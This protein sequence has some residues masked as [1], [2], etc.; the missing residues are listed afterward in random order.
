MKGK[1]T[2]RYWVGL[3]YFLCLAALI[4][5]T[6]RTRAQEIL[7]IK[8]IQVDIWPEYDRPEV[9]VIYRI[10]LAE[11]TVLPAGMSLRIP[12]QAAKPYNLAMRDMGGMLYNLDYTLRLEG[13]WIWVDFETPSTEIQLEYYDPRIRKDKLQRNFDFTWQESYY[14]TAMTVKVQQP[15]HS[16]TMKITPDM[17]SGNLGQDGLTYFTSMFNEVES[18]Q[19]VEVEISYEKSEDTLSTQLIPVLP[20][21][22]VSRQT[23][24]RTT[25]PPE[26]MWLLVGGAALAAAAGF[27]W[28]S[29]ARRTAP[30]APPPDGAEQEIAPAVN[31]APQAYCHRCGKRVE[32][33]DTF[34]RSCGANL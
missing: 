8:Q 26:L 10:S 21:E 13:E 1:R 25:V 34:C 32:T 20:S 6:S 17:G 27:F 4:F 9:L 12:T 5:M 14:I 16:Q 33:G 3:L 15:A 29:L 28:Y 11:G 30:A 2:N 24:G 18:D 31:A 19:L 7:E 22:P 23:T